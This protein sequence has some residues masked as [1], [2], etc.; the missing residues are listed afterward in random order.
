MPKSSMLNV[1]GQ[2][3]CLRLAGLVIDHVITMYIIS[4]RATQGLSSCQSVSIGAPIAPPCLSEPYRRVRSACPRPI[5]SH[6]MHELKIGLLN[7]TGVVEAQI[8]LL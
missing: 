4:R 2:A 7:L 3:L 8:A 1:K 6:S 5:P